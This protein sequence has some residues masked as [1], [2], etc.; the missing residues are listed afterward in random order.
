MYIQL[1]SIIAI[2]IVIYC[3]T[4]VLFMILH[5]QSFQTLDLYLVTLL[6]YIQYSMSSYSGWFSANN[7][8]IPIFPIPSL[9]LFYLFIIFLLV[10]QIGRS[11]WN[12]N[13]GNSGL[14]VRV[15]A[16]LTNVGR[17]SFSVQINSGVEL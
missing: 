8:C 14:V 7:F 2:S 6:L 3:K 10:I 17:P 12:G 5:F 9:Q 13:V 15:D 11:K 16:P 1:C 4:Q